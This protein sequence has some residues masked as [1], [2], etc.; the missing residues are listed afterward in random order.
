[1]VQAGY[2]AADYDRNCVV[3]LADLSAFARQWL[4]DIRLTEAVPY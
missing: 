2:N 3:D 1:M 4:D